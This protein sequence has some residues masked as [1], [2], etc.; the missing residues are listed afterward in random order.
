[1]SARPI[2]FL[3]APTKKLTTFLP[4]S[5]L[6]LEHPGTFPKVS[7][8]VVVGR[9]HSKLDNTP[10]HQK[11]NNSP[12]FHPPPYPSCSISIHIMLLSLCQNL[13]KI[14]FWS[15]HSI[16]RPSGGECKGVVWC[17]CSEKAIVIVWV[18]TIIEEIHFHFHSFTPTFPF[19][20]LV[21]RYITMVQL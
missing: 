4:P 6:G 10:E 2:K 3:S 9:K 18:L 13:I 19:F 14:L 11:F 5:F 16:V 1:M 21:K 8:K 17:A 20:K 12:H 7:G 15:S